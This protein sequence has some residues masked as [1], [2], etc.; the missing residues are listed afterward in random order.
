[1]PVL[2]LIHGGRY[3]EPLPKKPLPKAIPPPPVVRRNLF[4]V[5][6]EGQSPDQKGGNGK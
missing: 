3:D 6:E 5:A 1:M 4:D 2:T